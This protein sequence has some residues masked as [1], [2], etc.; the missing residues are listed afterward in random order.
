MKGTY[1]IKKRQL[2]APRQV[3]VVSSWTLSTTPKGMLVRRM[4]AL[5]TMHITY[6]SLCNRKIKQKEGMQ[7]QFLWDKSD[8]SMHFAFLK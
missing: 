8:E 6:P 1:W 7:G 3:R 5:N 4:N 2:S